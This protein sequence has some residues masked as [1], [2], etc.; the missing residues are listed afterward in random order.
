MKKILIFIALTLISIASFSQDIISLKKG[1]RREVIIMEISPTIVR[2]RLFSEPNG[3]MYFVYKEDIASIMYK[4]GRTESFDKVDVPKTESAPRATVN[5]Q[6]SSPDRNQRDTRTVNQSTNEWNNTNRVDNEPYNSS[7][8]RNSIYLSSNNAQDI[9]YLN[10]GSI[11][12]GRIIEQVPNQSIKI[13]IA[14]GSIF[15]YP[16]SSIAKVTKDASA[17]TAKSNYDE[18]DSAIDSE[19][20]PRFKAIVNMD[21]AIAMYNGDVQTG[22][23][24]TNFIGG[25]QF[26]PY[27]SAGTGVGLYY[28]TVNNSGHSTLI[29]VFADFR[30]NFSNKRIS[31][32]FSMD[33]GYLF[34]ASNDFTGVGLFLSPT[35]GVH[36]KVEGKFSIYAGMSYR[37]QFYNNSYYN[38]DNVGT[39]SPT[40]GFSF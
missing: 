6:S 26:N 10:N 25:V 22:T 27:F 18:D 28:Y 11:I 5:Q 7:Q 31:P 35:F 9:V 38:P 32:F 14:D 4:D 40:I 1:G 16:M 8:N 21:Y 3:R 17:V 34:D 13:Q 36:F 23:L 24:I 12:K 29:P 15:S 30:A 33:V 2:Y 19:S 20:R 39:I 37:L